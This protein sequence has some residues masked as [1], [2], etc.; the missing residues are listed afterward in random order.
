MAV[1]DANQNATQGAPGGNNWA[2]TGKQIWNTGQGNAV[3]NPQAVGNVGGSQAHT[4]M[5]PYTVLNFCI[6]LQ[7]FSR[8]QTRKEEKTWIRLSLK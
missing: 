5:Q 7:G 8:R 6:A 2:N 3:M 4:N 1:V